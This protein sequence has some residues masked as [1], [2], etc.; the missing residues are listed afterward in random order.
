MRI[1]LT[2]LF[3]LLS[4]GSGL[5]SPVQG[6][7]AKS[8]STQA[9]PV[10]IFIFIG[11]GMGENHI[12]AAKQYTLQNPPYT[13]WFQGWVSTYPFGGSYEPLRAWK[14]YDYVL[15]SL[16]T[17]SAAAATAIFSG[18]KTSNGRV[19]VS[20]DGVTRYQSITELAR[21]LGLGVGAVTTVPISH[22]TPAAWIAHNDS[23][24]NGF[25][26]ANEGIWGNPNTTGDQSMPSYGGGHGIS[27][28]PVDV[29]IGGGHPGWY[30]DNPYVDEK[31]RQKLIVENDLSGKHRFIERISGDPNGSAR[32]LNLA[33]DNETLKLVG[34]FGGANGNIEYRLADGSGANLENPSLNDMTLAAIQILNRNPKGFLLLVEGGAIDFASH[35][36]NMD[37]MIGELID[38]NSAIQTAIDWVNAS[39]TPANWSNTLMI[40]TADHETGYLTQAPGITANLPLGEVSPRTLLLEKS[41]I[42]SCWRASWEDDN[43]N[44]EIDAGEVV[45]WAWNSP[46]HTN[47]LVP[48]YLYGTMK[49]PY[50]ALIKGSDLIRGDYIDNTDIYQIMKATLLYRNSLYLP[51]IYHE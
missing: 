24:L 28:P 23:R 18:Q 34:L 20:P 1:I 12:Q 48:L 38:F 50:S 40:V 42:T 36:N 9:P 47:S 15:Q 37:E 41:C 27:D 32:L 43:N 11:D 14:D 5:T 51:V 31:I 49:L 30:L 13:D 39:F 7:S 3:V 45:Y 29:L 6:I 2:L 46:G 21:Q 33:R 35:R 17:D 44:N 26:I 4:L 19:N 22:A 10:Y 16:I 8:D 25:A